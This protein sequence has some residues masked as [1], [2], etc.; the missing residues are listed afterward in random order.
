MPDTSGPPDPVHL[1]AAIDHF[2]EL[3]TSFPARQAERGEFIDQL[4]EAVR[5]VP[6][7]RLLIVINDEYLGEL[8]AYERRLSPFP[9]EYIRLSSL[10]TETALDAIT[11]PLR[12]TRRE[13]AADVPQKIVDSLTTIEYTDIAGESATV[14]SDSVEPLLL[15]IACS[16]LWASVPDGTDLITSDHLQFYGQVDQALRRFYDAAIDLVRREMEE[17]EEQLRAWIE[18][19][20]ITEHGTRGTA[21][22]GLISTAGMPA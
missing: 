6:A 2:E 22:L 4:A 16:D 17:T 18:S 1:L 20:F 15:Q 9:L 10:S 8:K 7:I 11:G 21:S 3:F 13:F 14:H 19:T 12:G 5:R